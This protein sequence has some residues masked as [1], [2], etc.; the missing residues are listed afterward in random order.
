MSASARSPRSARLT[1]PVMALSP[2]ARLPSLNRSMVP[3]RALGIAVAVPVVAVILG[4]ASSGCDSSLPDDTTGGPVVGAADD[5]CSGVTPV[6]I[7]PASCTARPPAGGGA[8]EANPVHFNAE[9]DDDDCKYHVSFTATSVRQN[10]DATFK[11]AVTSL[12]GTK[13][14]VVGA[15][16]HI[17]G[18]LN[19]AVAIAN[20]NPTTTESPPGTYTIGPVKFPQAGLWVIT[21][22]LFETCA[23]LTD[24]PHGHAS[25]YID[26][27]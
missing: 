16:P 13:G 17:E 9:S 20:T 15:E 21:Y 14:P 18:T 7:N 5:H 26:V 23:D 1:S 10:Q 11:V 3:A 4:V 22:H 6:V 27:P 2:R 12:A 25:F 19:D 24:S 8:T